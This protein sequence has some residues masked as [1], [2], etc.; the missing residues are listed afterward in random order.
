MNRLIGVLVGSEDGCL[1]MSTSNVLLLVDE[2]NTWV[3]FIS[4]KGEGQ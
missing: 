3:T 4:G 2:D 1:G